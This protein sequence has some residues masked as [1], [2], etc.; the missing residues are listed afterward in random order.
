M[1][2]DKPRAARHGFRLRRGLFTKYLSLLVSL[3]LVII[4]LLSGM[5]LIFSM[6]YFREEKEVSLFQTA[7]TAVQLTLSNYST[8][9]GQYLQGYV[10]SQ[11]FTLLSATN[12][13]TLFLVDMQGQTAICT[14]GES[15]THTAYH[16]SE[17]IIESCVQNGSYAETGFLG[18]IYSSRQVTVARPVQS[19][20]ETI[21]LIFVSS[22][23]ASL[24]EYMS[25][26][27]LIFVIVSVVVFVI[28]VLILYFMT[29]S[30]TMP[31]V[32]MAAA[33][34]QF[35]KGDFTARITVQGDDEIAQLGRAF[36]EM[37]T[38]LSAL[39]NSRRSFVANVSHELKTPMT[40]IGGFIDGILDGTIPPDKQEHYL[41]IVRDEISRL[42]R[43]VRSMLSLSRL[44]SGDMVIKPADFDIRDI[45]VQTVFAFE[46]PIEAKNL[47]IRGLDGG[48]A[49]VR[50]DRDLFHQVVYNLVDNA[51]KFVNKGGY[52]DFR[53]HP[54]GAFTRVSIRNSGPGIPRTELNS[55]FDRFYKTDRSRSLDKTGV[56]L[57]LYI[58]KSVVT[59][60]G[61]TITVDSKEGEY[62]EFA[63]T[64][65]GCSFD[66]P[67]GGTK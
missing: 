15:C 6:R 19:D 47:E 40:T 51:V 58:V 63:F 53:I 29:R 26:I 2:S 46:Q 18:G 43:M 61:G 57:G 56:G 17:Q 32:H 28:S 34:E 41:R 38:A 9:D 35:S 60:H 55:V 3:L 67:E 37:A 27:L 50:A 36:N 64:V 59:L 20:G 10:L 1:K 14:E 62:T 4:V 33:T 45:L 44:D 52:I 49:M 30:M 31:L 5:Q 7:D 13:C 23:A 21:C 11:G 54:E 22:S 48:K 39:E 8:T 66:A 16:V 25:E 65:P 24:D 12:N 42:S